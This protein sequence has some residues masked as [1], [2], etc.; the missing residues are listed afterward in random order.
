[1][2]ALRGRDASGLFP[3][4]WSAGAKPADRLN[5]VTH[6]RFREIVEEANDPDSTI[7][8]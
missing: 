6:E 5:I 4:S 3:R 1:M 2:K 7:R 8:L